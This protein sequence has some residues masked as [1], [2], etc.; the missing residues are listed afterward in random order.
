VTSEEIRTLIENQ[1]DLEEPIYLAPADLKKI[2]VSEVPDET[3][4]GVGRLDSDSVIHVEWDGQLVWLNGELSAEVDNSWTRKYWY[5]PI[6]LEHY[7]DLVRRAVENRESLRGD[8]HII[9]SDDDG[10]YVQLAYQIMGLPVGGSLADAYEYAL[11]VT[12]EIEEPA[13]SATAETGRLVEA[14]IRRVE[15]WGELPL[16]K[17]VEAVELATTSAD[18]GRTLE[19][20]VTRLFESV[21]GFQTTGRIRTETEEIDITVLNGSADPRFSRESAVILVECK[22]WTVKCGKDE[23][24][25]FHSKL[26]NRSKRCSLGFLVSWNG[27]TSTVSREMLRG[28]RELTLVVPLDGRQ[29]RDAVRRNS[30]GELLHSVWDSTVMS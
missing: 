1:H 9:H 6:N 22:N 14:H 26:E 19:E 18:K 13:E 8:V 2:K 7:L 11:H 5:M 25:V 24:V 3:R 16:D 20:L 28:T 30:F 15:R 17:L 10:A 21:D 4:I 29:I 27:F 23:F 12:E